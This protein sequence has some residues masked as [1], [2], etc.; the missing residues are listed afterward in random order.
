MKLLIIFSIVLFSASSFAG[1]DLIRAKLKSCISQDDSASNPT[2]IECNNLAINQADKEI[3]ELTSAI[4][5]KLTGVDA[6][7]RDLSLARPTLK[8]EIASFYVYRDSAASIAGVLD[9]GTGSD[10]FVASTSLKIE[11]TLNELKS[12]EQRN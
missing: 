6:H 8:K 12:L 3:K 10:I 9:G 5:E 4:L 2:V 1:A 7:G 11:L